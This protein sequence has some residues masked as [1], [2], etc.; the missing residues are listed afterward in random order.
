MGSSGSCSSP[1]SCGC[2]CHKM[3]RGTTGGSSITESLQVSS[4]VNLKVIQPHE[5]DGLALTGHFN[6]SRAPGTLWPIDVIGHC[7]WEGVPR[8]FLT[9][10]SSSRPFGFGITLGPASGSAD[11][12]SE[13]GQDQ[14]G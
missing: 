1:S 12:D 8:Q 7:W 2:S 13:M 4:T 5:I 9:P 10:D 11:T 6:F 14:Y 3:L